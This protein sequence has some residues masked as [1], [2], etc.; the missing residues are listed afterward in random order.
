MEQSRTIP[1]RIEDAFTATLRMPLPRLFSRWYRPIPPIKDVADQ[2]GEWGTVGQRR[3]VLLTGGSH[4]R[5]ALIVDP[6]QAFGYQLCHVT[7]P[8]SPLVGRVEGEWLFR[9]GGTAVTWRWV[10]HPG[11]GFAAPALVPLGRLWRG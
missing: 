2:D 5:E 3:T 8:L 1:V 11:S 6:P 9:P 7:G 4:M 10:V